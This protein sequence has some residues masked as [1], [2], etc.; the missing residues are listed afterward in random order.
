MTDEDTYARDRKPFPDLSRV[1]RVLIDDRDTSH[2]MAQAANADREREGDQ[3][4]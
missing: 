1:R 4:E 3:T 2:H